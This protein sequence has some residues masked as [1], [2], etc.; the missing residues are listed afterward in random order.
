MAASKKSAVDNYANI[1]AVTAIPSAADAFKSVKFAFP[2]SI[3][4]KMGLLLSRI[5]Y[6]IDAFGYLNSANDYVYAGLS[7][8]SSLTSISDP[9]DPMIVD[10]IRLI[11]VDY[12][13]A[14]SGDLVQ[15]PIIRDFSTLPGGGLLVAPNPLYFWT[16]TNGASGVI[17]CQCRLWYTYMELSTDDYWQLVESRRVISS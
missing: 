4:D 14:A 17:S 9:A 5:E 7:T 2:F 15:T 12:G 16:Q 10:S 1:A 13:T 11:R 8:A 3:M 6:F